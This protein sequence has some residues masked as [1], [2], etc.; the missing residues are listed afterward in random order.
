[1]EF[2]STWA[3][4]VHW[5]RTSHLPRRQPSCWRALPRGE[6]DPSFRQSPP[7]NKGLLMDGWG[8]RCVSLTKKGPPS[9]HANPFV[10]S[11]SRT[12]HSVSTVSSQNGSPA[13]LPFSSRG[14]RAGRSLE[15]IHEMLHRSR[16]LL[17]RKCTTKQKYNQPWRAFHGSQISVFR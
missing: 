12:S 15:P 5:R 3:A 17:M 11:R 13:Q 16:A 2:V 8:L 7:S 1:M 6:H 9:Q 10:A 4:S 14:F